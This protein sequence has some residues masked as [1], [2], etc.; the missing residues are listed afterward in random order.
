MSDFKVQFV[1]GL[2]PTLTATVDVNAPT[3]TAV[4]DFNKSFIVPANPYNG[5][6][7]G[8][9]TG[10]LT[11]T[12][13]NHMGLVKLLD[14]DTVR[15][16]DNDSING[17]NNLCG[18]FVVEYLG[19]SG[20]VNE[21]IVRAVLDLSGTAGTFDSAPIAGIGNIAKC[22]PFVTMG[23]NLNSSASNAH[24]AKVEVVNNGTDN[25]VR[26]TKGN[27]V[28]TLFLRVYVVEF[29]GSNWTIQ[30]VSHTFA[31]SNVD[32]DDVINAVTLANSWVYSTYRGASGTCAQNLFYVYLSDTTHLR[33]RVL[34]RVSASHQTISY[35]IS[36]PQMTV[37]VYG[38]NPDGTD[39]LAAGGS[40]PETRNIAISAIPNINTA[41]ITAHMG[42]SQ[43]A[44][45]NLPAILSMLNFT[46]TTNIQVRRSDNNGGTEYK[47]Q[48][49]DFDAVIGLE[50][51]NVTTPLVDGSNFTITGSFG[52]L[53]SVTLGGVAQAAVSA[54]STTIVRTATLGTLKYGA[55][56]LVVTAGGV[57]TEPLVQINPPATK[58][59][60]D[61]STVAGSGQRITA[62]PDLAAGDQIEW[63]NVVG[64]TIADVSVFDDATFSATPG[65]TAFD[66]RV[67]DGTGWGTSATQ[68]VNDA[69]AVVTNIIMKIVTDFTRLI[70]FALT[71]IEHDT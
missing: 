62:T 38:N 21:V 58:N 1:E 46:S 37:T 70:T 30:K 3:F 29:V 41:L 49:V 27:T 66:V 14:I 6:G 64:G 28:D 18:G 69:P 61:L 35:V 17:R 57:V 39:D 51:T 20:G 50:I 52:T 13:A 71:N 48:V 68:T 67:N 32:E 24:T 11:N 54:N 26:V 40:F 9:T 47:I 59:Y 2:I 7:I 8:H 10:S 16:D 33:H 31:A 12:L 43:A 44:S 22:V 25:V 36:N 34:V 19:P 63:S 42:S 15:F 5:C 45:T 60:V 65:V 23:S 55:Y 56:D 4:A 53:T